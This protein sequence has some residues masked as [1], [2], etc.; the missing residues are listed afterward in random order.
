TEL[1]I[2]GILCLLT[3]SEQ[4]EEHGCRFDWTWW[5][6]R[7]ERGFL[8]LDWLLRA[9]MLEDGRRSLLLG[10]WKKNPLEE[11]KQEPTD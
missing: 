9:L 2:G 8:L 11:E 4:I 5:G 6:T 3:E 7:P 10:Y 1:V